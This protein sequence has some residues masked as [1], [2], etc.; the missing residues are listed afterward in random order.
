MVH[1]TLFLPGCGVSLDGKL[2]AELKEEQLGKGGG[3]VEEERG[4]D[5]G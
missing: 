2:L 4:Q 5:G 3:M 1:D